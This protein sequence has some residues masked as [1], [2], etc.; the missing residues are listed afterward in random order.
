MSIKIYHAGELVHTASKFDEMEKYIQADDAHVKFPG[1]EFW[2]RHGKLHRD[3]DKPAGIMGGTKTWCQNGL[4][5]RDGDKPA[6]TGANGSKSW[7]QHGKEHRDGDKPAVIRPEG[8]YWFQH[9]VRYRPRDSEPSS[10]TKKGKHFTGTF[11]DKKG[12]KHR[13]GGLPAVECSCGKNQ[14]WIHGKRQP[15]Q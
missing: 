11:T 3:G 7:Y 13:S 9:G 2:F 1:G 14:W 10:I 6:L 15:D 4:I 12:R 5:H 8:M